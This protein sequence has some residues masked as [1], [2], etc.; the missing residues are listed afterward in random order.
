MWPEVPAEPKGE[1]SKIASPG[2]SKNAGDGLMETY[3]QIYN[4][5]KDRRLEI[6]RKLKV[7]GATVRKLLREGK[8]KG[9]KLPNGD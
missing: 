8:L 6:V 7:P 3:H 4:I 1:F 2:P 9:T 5:N